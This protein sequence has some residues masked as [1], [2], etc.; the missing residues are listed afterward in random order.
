MEYCHIYLQSRNRVAIIGL[1]QIPGSRLP[2]QANSGYS[3]VL[4]NEQWKIAKFYGVVWRL[5]GYRADWIHSNI[6]A[7]YLAKLNYPLRWKQR[8]DAAKAL[9]ESQ[10]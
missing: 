10:L 8:E 5:K 9:I 7:K 1:S 6:P 2:C 4:W 3:I